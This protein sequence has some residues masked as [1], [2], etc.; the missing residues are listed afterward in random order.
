MIAPDE[1]NKLLEA[2]TD[3]P[4]WESRNDCHAGPIATIHH[5]LNNDWVEVWSTNGPD[6]EQEQEANVALIARAP[7]IA[8]AYIA[9][10]E[11][12]RWTR[13]GIGKNPAKHRTPVLLSDGIYVWAANWDEHECHHGPARS[14]PTHW[15]PL[16]DAQ[17]EGA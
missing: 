7:E 1:V 16:P 2:A 17:K 12:R 15:M 9:L 4:W 13:I 6:G 14:Y 8:A 5:C 11:E 10:S 3:G